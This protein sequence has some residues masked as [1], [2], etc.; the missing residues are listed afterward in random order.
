MLEN[1]ELLV[2]DMDGTLIDSRGMY[3]GTYGTV[4]HGFGVEA[5]EEQIM[6][7][8]V[9]KPTA[10]EI[11]P[12]FSKDMEGREGKIQKAATKID[13]LISS[14]VGISMLKLMPYARETLQAMAELGY[15]SA[16]HTGSNRPFT[17]ACLEHYSL[18]E[19]WD[20]K[21]TADDPFEDR[22]AAAK[23]IVNCFT[24]PEKTVYI[25]DRV[26]DVRTAQQV[27]CRSIAVSGGWDE[28]A[29][30]RAANPD[31]LVSSLQALYDEMLRNAVRV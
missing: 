25:G 7:S 23:Y 3:T 2:F 12:L 30:L 26:K 8:L 24:T 19:Y 16:L 6:S 13:E 15:Y 4:L 5:T 20:L 17:E 21:V 18:N 10:E 29:K 11:E 14:E 31:Y 1:L 9:G 22:V 27:G 28:D